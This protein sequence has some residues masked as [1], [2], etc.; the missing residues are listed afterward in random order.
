[1]DVL[2]LFISAQ[3]VEIL[4]KILKTV[5]ETCPKNFSII[6]NFFIKPGPV[7]SEIKEPFVVNEKIRTIKKFIKLGNR[8]PKK[9]QV[10]AV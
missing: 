5:S 4:K 3:T 10:N 7:R 1:M 6:D 9:N 2:S 8:P